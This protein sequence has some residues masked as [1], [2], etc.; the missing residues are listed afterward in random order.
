MKSIFI[1]YKKPI[2]NNLLSKIYCEILKHD[3]TLLLNSIIE[4]VIYNLKN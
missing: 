4:M 2:F 3:I 1:I